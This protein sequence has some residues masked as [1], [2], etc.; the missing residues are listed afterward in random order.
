MI[1]DDGKARLATAGRSSIVTG[2][3]PGSNLQE[4]STFEV[5]VPGCRY[6]APE[7]QRAE[8]SGVREIPITQDSDV[9]GMSMVIYEVRSRQSISFSPGVEPNVNLLG[10]HREKAILRLQ[11]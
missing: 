7:I 3:D 8:R 10:T 9:Y 4:H 2:L 5:D 1:D 6:S 11:R